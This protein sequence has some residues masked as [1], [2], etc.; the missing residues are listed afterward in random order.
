MEIRN[1]PVGALSDAALLRRAAVGDAALVVTDLD[2]GAGLE[3]ARAPDASLTSVVVGVTDVGEPPNHVLAS[4]CDVVLPR[5]DR[6][7]LDAIT[8]TVTGCPVA[9]RSLAVLLRAGERRSLDGGLLAE[10]AVYSALQGGS[11][12]EA[13]RAS[14]P[15]RP[16]RA[17]DAPVVVARNEGVLHII[18]DRPHVQN[19]L[20]IAMRDALVDALDLAAVDPSVTEIHLRGMGAAFCAGGDL[21]EFGT[22][23]DPAS[24][25]LVRLDRSI[26]RAA[27]AVSDRLI[28]HLHGACIGSGIEIP[29]FART[30]LADPDTTIALP[31][32]SLGLIPGAGGTVSLPRRI[33]RHRTARL[34]LTGLPIDA[35]TALEWG[36]VDGVEARPT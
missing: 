23:A 30:V 14:R 3:P 19:A 24:A 16:R 1:V 18:L 5:S 4:L 17:E 32:L 35:T 9:S 11:E 29:A 33:G 36:L 6:T 25:H 20:D 31:E 8:A 26:A 10:S 13:W 12:F 34:A 22:F 21:D 27:A 15:P 2:A 7:A 28:A